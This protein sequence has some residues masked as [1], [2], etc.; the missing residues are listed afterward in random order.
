MHLARA[1]RR[2]GALVRQQHAV[3]GA[4]LVAALGSLADAPLR[5]RDDVQVSFG[6]EPGEVR[7]PVGKE[8]N[9]LGG[10]VDAGEVGGLLPAGDSGIGSL[11][12][13]VG[14]GGLVTLGRGELVLDQGECRPEMLT[15]V[16]DPS[17]RVNHRGMWRSGA[18][19]APKERGYRVRGRLLVELEVVGHVAPSLGSRGRQDPACHEVGHH[20]QLVAVG[21]V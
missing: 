10:G 4:T 12:A 19:R 1:I 20:E 14:H 16:L 2:V 17:V 3:G 11:V 7:N 9:P 6:K 13:L 15:R 8:A 5:P 18:C 21:L